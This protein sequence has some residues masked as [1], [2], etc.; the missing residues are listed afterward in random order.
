MTLPKLRP[1]FTFDQERLDALA[2]IAPEAFADGKINWETLREALG[3]HLE[4]EEQGSEHFGLFWPGKRAARRQASTPS[5]GTLKPAPGQGVNE[6]NTRHLFI[7]GDNLEVL[8]LLQK[9]YAGR[10]KM[11]YIDPPYNTGNDFIYSDNFAQPLDEYLRATGQADEMGRVLVT[12]TKSGGRYHSNWL[13]MMY[14]RLRLARNLLR[15]DGVIF[16]SIDDNEVHNLR[17]LMNEVFGEENF[18]A[19]I[20]IQSNPRGR[21]SENFVASVHEYILLYA[22]N[23]TEC[24]LRGNQLTPEQLAEFNLT[25]EHGNKYRLL[26]LRQRGSASRREDRPKMFFPIYVDPDTGT[27]ALEKTSLCR[28]EVLPRKSTGED[29]RWMWS[30]Q[31]VKTNLDLVETRLITRRDEWDIFVRDFLSSSEGGERTRK[32][33]TIWDEREF[34]YQNGTQEVKELLNGESV[35]E[36]PKPVAL[37]ERIIS[38]IIDEDAIVLDFFAGTCPLAHATMKL[39]RSE[40]TEMR[41]IVVQVPEPIATNST[42][43]RAGF[44]TIADIG[45]ERIRRVIQRLQAEGGGQL[46]LAERETPEDLGFRVFKLA[47]SH[48]RAWQDFEGGDV[49]GLQSLFDRFESPLTPGWQADDLL[50]EVLLMEGFPLDSRIAPAPDFLHNRVQVVTSDL[51]AHRLF[52]CLDARIDDATSAALSLESDD[53]FIC[54][55]AAL[56]D[57]AKVRLEDGRRVKVI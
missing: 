21:Q 12:N 50:A 49:A 54:L 25:D 17:S 46:P 28:V 5:A 24:S 26:G 41:F 23:T 14:P 57:E 55:D 39:N 15:D 8:K 19:Q 37:L 10:V 34:N 52:V 6:A 44:A 32:I 31:K 51:V 40:S 48:F 1:T 53:L 2:A 56:S 35:A 42:A 4:E 16:V 9:S 22:K 45:K 20:I 18:I 33:K 13:N 3:D 38:Q 43:K 30:S 36:Y 29:G 11:I 47:R 27:I 7:E